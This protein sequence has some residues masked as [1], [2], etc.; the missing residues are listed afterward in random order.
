MWQLQIYKCQLGSYIIK[1]RNHCSIY[2]FV[3]D[4]SLVQVINAVKGSFFIVLK[5][6]MGYAKVLRW[7]KITYTISPKSQSGFVAAHNKSINIFPKH[8]FDNTFKTRA[9][10]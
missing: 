7:P 5:D 4:L 1:F 2:S 10:E 9:P 6:L 3:L 8:K